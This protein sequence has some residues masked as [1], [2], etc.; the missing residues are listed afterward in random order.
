MIQPQAVPGTIQQDSGVGRD[1]RDTTGEGDAEYW[2]HQWEKYEEDNAIVDVDVRGW[3]FTPQ[4]GPL[5]RKHRLF[6]GLARQL[7]G[8]PA[9]A[10]ESP[11][12]SPSNSRATSPAKGL[13]D[14]LR[15]QV[16]NVEAELVAKD[17]QAII[18]KGEREAANA[19]LGRYSEKPWDEPDRASIYSRSESTAGFERLGRSST[20]SSTSSYDDPNITPVQKRA[21][22]NTPAQMSP[23]QLTVANTNL[24]ARLQPFLSVPLA[25]MPISAFF[26]NE[27][28]SRQK[29]FTT[30]A[31]GHFN[32]RAG[33]DFV[34]T[35]VRVLAS[36]NLS[37][38]EK[39]LITEPHGVSVISDIDDTIKHSAVTS[40]AREIFRNVFIRD[41]G[42]LFI[43][44][45]KEWYQ[46]LAQ[47]GVKFHYVSN[48]P[49]QLF[50]VLTEYFA[51]AGLPP[52]SMHLKQYSGMFQ[53]I[54]EPVAERKKGTL[55]RI[56]RDF[57]DRRFLLIGDSGEA[58]LEVYTEVVL[59][60]PGR[61]LGIFIR[62]VTTTP[63]RGFFD[64][65]MGPLADSSSA[66][67]RCQP[68]SDEEDDADMKAAI[69]AS[70]R[71][72]EKTGGAAEQRPNLPPPPK[73][74]EDLIDLNWEDPPAKAETARSSQAGS[75]TSTTQPQARRKQ[76]PPR[77]RKP[78]SA[79]QTNISSLSNPTSTNTIKSTPSTTTTS[80]TPDNPI[81]PPTD[82]STTNPTRERE[83]RPSLPTRRPL[84]SYP[85]SAA[86]TAARYAS[87]IYSSASSV[88][89]Q[90]YTNNSAASTA[91]SNLTGSAQRSSGLVNQMAAMDAA[92]FGGAADVLGLPVSKKEE[93]W[94]RR[95]ARAKGIMDDKG[96]VLRT[97]RVGG[98]VSAETLRLVEETERGSR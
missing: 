49:W 25:N 16:S 65:A 14:R 41:L 73:E 54:F 4:K 90:S 98:D 36:E 97:W 80:N 10:E 17:A 51:Q 81:Q 21:S 31:S 48:S 23:A 5:S 87:S 44:G 56:F 53:G 93:M 46:R 50:P 91:A 11:G 34:P 72:F 24:L 42:D 1:S 70:L 35:H 27:N 86:T 40:G 33:L 96:V 62:D 18:D 39:V 89:H 12:S 29:T 57:P 20:R 60:H 45:V 7:V 58:D 88:Y 2:R 64:S 6:I 55:D 78:S 8:V 3:L 32:L 9:P 59:E 52:G 67:S 94:K 75:A 38:T 71:E 15:H 83:P 61:V 82:S 69:A 19:A 37:L 28:D 68:H 63:K 92:T 66:S 85:T 43:D 77:P 47:A 74:E 26:Y 76:P 95:W 30:D 22:W 13:K 84:S 79:V